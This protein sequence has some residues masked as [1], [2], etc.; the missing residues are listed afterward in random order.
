MATVTATLDL[1]VLYGPPE[2]TRKEILFIL[3]I[4]SSME[5]SCKG[6]PRLPASDVRVVQPVTSTCCNNGI[7]CCCMRS[8]ISNCQSESPVN[9]V[10]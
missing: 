1:V 2:S 9:T 3:V 5:N 10:W 8:S 4:P 6:R 7:A